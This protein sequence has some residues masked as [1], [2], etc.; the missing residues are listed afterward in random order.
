VLVL[1]GLCTLVALEG[2]GHLNLTI[3]RSSSAYLTVALHPDMNVQEH[4]ALF[5][6]MSTVLS[7]LAWVGLI[8]LNTIPMCVLYSVLFGFM[9]AK[10]MMGWAFPLSL[11]DDSFTH[12]VMAF[13]FLYLFIAKV[14]MTF[15]AVWN[16]ALN[17]RQ[18]KGQGT[19][20]K[21]FTEAPLVLACAAPFFG[22]LWALSA[23][24][25]T[26]AQSGIVW[27][28]AVG[29]A[30]LC[31]TTRARELYQA[32]LT[33]GKATR[34]GSTVPN[35]EAHVSACLPCALL[36]VFWV[37]FA[38]ATSHGYDRDLVV[39]LSSLTLLCTTHGA[40]LKGL[41]PVTVVAGFCAVFWVLS[42]L[43]AVLI[44]GY[45]VEPLLADFEKPQDYFHLDSDMSVWTNVSLKWPL[46]NLAQVLVPLPAIAAGLRSQ[47][48]RS[49]DVLFVFALLSLIPV[50]A[51]HLSS[52]R[53]LGVLGLLLAAAKGYRVGDQQQRSDRLI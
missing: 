38:A 42:T 24:L 13:P 8:P 25:Y 48:G 16:P 26:Q 51:A 41:S 39:P 22:L 50:F 44:K 2:F 12:H 9:S 6:F 37:S 47:F 43:Y 45:G 36:T 29:F 18:T 27:S 30:T 4:P 52:L 33:T 53:Y 11:A 15:V 28:A 20:G 21:M 35:S 17:T 49:E 14:L 23:N 32:T 10:A 46:L 40:V 34:F 1:G 19:A 5:L 31:G 7:G 3:E